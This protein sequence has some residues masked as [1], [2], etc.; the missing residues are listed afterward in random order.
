MMDMTHLL[1]IRVGE[2]CGLING[3]FCTFRL[4]GSHAREARVQCT[5]TL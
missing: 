2:Q 1:P 5:Q 3:P 4:V